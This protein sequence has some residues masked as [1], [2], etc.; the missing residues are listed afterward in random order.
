MRTLCC[1]VAALC[2]CAA[3]AEDRKVEPVRSWAGILDEKKLTEAV[4]PKGY[5]TSRAG[6]EKLWKAW[7]P[8]EKLPEVDFEKHLVLVDLGGMYPLGYELKLT[9]K[10]DLRVRLLAKVPGK[11]G[12]GYGIAVIERSGVKSIKGKAIKPD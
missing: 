8:G 9:D 7:R 4:P 2:V 1:L 6:W 10:G 11:R 12:Y 5:L 3:R